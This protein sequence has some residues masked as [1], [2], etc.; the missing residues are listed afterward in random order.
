MYI[1]PVF[2]LFSRVHATLFSSFFYLSFPTGYHFRMMSVYLPFLRLLSRFPYSFLGA[3]SPFRTFCPS[4]LQ[5]DR[6]SVYKFTY[7]YIHPFSGFHSRVFIPGNLFI[8][9]CVYLFRAFL[10]VFFLIFSARR[11][12]RCLRRRCV[13]TLRRRLLRRRRRIH[14]LRMYV[15]SVLH[16]FVFISTL[17]TR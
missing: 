10:R 15:L 17:L 14:I 2:L 8:C 7:L 16:S 12:F 11:H 9:S 1:L 13:S 4:V 3:A 6:P 5:R